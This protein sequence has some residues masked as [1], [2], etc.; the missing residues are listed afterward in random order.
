MNNLLKYA[1]GLSVATVFGGAVVAS[2]AQAIVVGSLAFSDGTDD[3]FSEVAPGAGDTF[4]IE[5][6]P[7]SLNFVTTQD[8]Y[9]TPPF[10]GSP[11][12]GVAP[13]EA[14]FEFVSSSGS[15]FTYAL[16]NDLVFAFNNGA[17]VTWKTGTEFMGMFNL[18][19][20]VEFMLAEE[21]PMPMVMGIGE[22]DFF[23]ISDTLQFSDTSASGGGT[24]NGQVDIATDIP[25]PTTLFGL[26]IV[27]AGLAVSRRK[28]QK[29]S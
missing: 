4:S 9:F 10:D 20:A 27:T 7:F 2:P 29:S 22:T 6:N 16:T 12:Q 23:V 15:E 21:Q 19:N 25:E 17:S 8:G 5:F 14:N 11:V 24:Y 13:Y 28:S 1:I 18:N 3:W 26:G